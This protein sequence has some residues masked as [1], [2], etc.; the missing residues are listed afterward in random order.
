MR[1]MIAMLLLILGLL[2]CSGCRTTSGVIQQELIR[3]T[4]QM[5]DSVAGGDQAPWKKYFAEDCM[6]FN[7][8]GRNMNKDALV[9]DVTPLPQGYSGTIT[10]AKVQSHIEGDVAILSYDL[11]ETEIIFGQKMKARYHRRCRIMSGR[12]NWL[13]GR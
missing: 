3:R 5:F 8:V 2:V 9:A 7:E 10:M 12:T 11:D 1:Q 4:Q 13:P 6:Y